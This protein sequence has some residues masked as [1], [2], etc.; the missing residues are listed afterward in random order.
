MRENHEDHEVFRL[1]CISLGQADK[2]MEKD[3]WF[4]VKDSGNPL[5]KRMKEQIWK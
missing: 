5:G 1:S 3:S 2:I 4:M